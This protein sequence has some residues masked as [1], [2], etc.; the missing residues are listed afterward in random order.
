M[1]EK[2]SKTTQSEIIGQGYINVGTKRIMYVSTDSY[3]KNKPLET[4]YCLVSKESPDRNAIIV[5]TA[6]KGFFKSDVAK[7]FIKTA[8]KGL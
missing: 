5:I 2:F 7:T 8:Y 3:N 1:L 6:N 4:M